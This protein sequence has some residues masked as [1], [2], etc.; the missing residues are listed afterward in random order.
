MENLIVPGVVVQLTPRVR[1]LTAP[2]PGMMTG[3]GTN[4]YI[5]GTDELT[6]IDP[7]PEIDTHIALLI[8]TVGTRLKRI[9]TTHTH[10]DH[11]PA[12][13]ALRSATGAEV[14]GMADRIGRVA[15]GYFADIVAVRGDPLADVNVTLNGVTWVMKG[16]QVVVDKR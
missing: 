10:F 16:G 8:A 13:R 12:A 14:L 4:S 15:P 11:S 2:N 3:P 6:V 5:V 1:R 7:G 9:L